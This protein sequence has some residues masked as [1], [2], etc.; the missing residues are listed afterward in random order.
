MVFVTHCLAFALRHLEGMKEW[1]KTDDVFVGLFAI[2]DQNINQHKFNN[3]VA[4]SLSMF[5]TYG[6][7]SATPTV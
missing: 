2:D 3:C 5:G 6:E 4:R 1:N 7:Y